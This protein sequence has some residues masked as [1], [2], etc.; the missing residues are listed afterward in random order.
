MSKKKIIIIIIAIVTLILIII[1]A[2]NLYNIV[3]QI[4]VKTIDYD[5]K[6]SYTGADFSTG[7][8]ASSTSYY[9]I[10]I[11]R[12]IEYEIN[13]Y[14]VYGA[15]ENFWKRGDN[16]SI[17]KKEISQEYIDNLLRYQDYPSKVPSSSELLV[18]RYE[19]IEFKD[20]NKQVYLITSVWLERN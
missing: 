14:Y 3:I 12:K 11:D 5:I 2:K 18:N 17:K 1:N 13:N 9:L 20:T 10:D 7:G 15:E 6:V 16:Y 8:Y 4:Y 19:I